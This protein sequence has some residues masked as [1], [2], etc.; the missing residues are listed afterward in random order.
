MYIYIYIYPATAT[1][2]HINVKERKKNER[3]VKR[4]KGIEAQRVN[5]PTPSRATDVLIG[6]E[7]QNGKLKRTKRNR[8]RVPNPVN[9][10]HS[11]TSYNV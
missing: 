8:E 9:L 4:K 1:S 5:H 6:D 10:D 2:A 3:R 11:V 7:E